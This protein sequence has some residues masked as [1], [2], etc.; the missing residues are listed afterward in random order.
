MRWARMLLVTA[1]CIFAFGGVMHALAYVAKAAPQITNAHVAPF[2]GAELRGLWLIDSTTLLALACL[3]ALVAARPS[4]AGGP[5]VMVV[6]LVPAATAMVLYIFLG[7]FYAAHML[8]AAAAMVFVAG[9][10]MPSGSVH[11]Q[12]GLRP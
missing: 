8:M 9:W 2:F 3:C 7:G 12:G 11:V 6:A 4:T 1:A 10:L 5:V